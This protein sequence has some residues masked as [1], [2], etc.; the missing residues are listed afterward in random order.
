MI[1]KHTQGHRHDGVALNLSN[2]SRE[3]TM[4]A[5]FLSNLMQT[6]LLQEDL[7]ARTLM[8]ISYR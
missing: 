6:A 4:V 8:S 2:E 5:T 7:R 3:V 1:L